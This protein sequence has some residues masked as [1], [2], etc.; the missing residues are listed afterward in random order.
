MADEMV[1]VP[2]RLLEELAALLDKNDGPPVSVPGNGEWTEKMVRQLQAELVRH[3]GARAVADE[4]AHRPGE[5]VSLIEVAEH[6]RINK[7]NISNDLSGMSKTTR[8]L[9]GSKRW[10]FR[11]VDTAQGMHYVMQPEIARWWL[12]G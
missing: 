11:A 6:A 4:V 10:P 5:L 8:R 12:A 9:F 1:Q 3:P 7:Q 2:R